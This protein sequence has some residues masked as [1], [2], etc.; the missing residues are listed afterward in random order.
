MWVEPSLEKK[1][2]TSLCIFTILLLMYIM[3]IRY[4]KTTKT[5]LKNHQLPLG[6]L[7]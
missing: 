7:G 6:L 4:V 5:P 1:E 3:D 2:L